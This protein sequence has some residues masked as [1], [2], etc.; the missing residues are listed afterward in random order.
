MNESATSHSDDVSGHVPKRW[1]YRKLAFGREYRKTRLAVRCAI[2]GF[3]VLV[4]ISML[5]ILFPTHRTTLGL[6]VSAFMLGGELLRRYFRCL[7]LRECP[8]CHKRALTVHLDLAH[9]SDVDPGLDWF[10]ADCAQC[11]KQFRFDADG[12]FHDQ[13]EST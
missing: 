6:I 11:K 12:T 5:W 7:G 10:P 3:V 8:A 1:T 13:H 2:A 9:E 4:I